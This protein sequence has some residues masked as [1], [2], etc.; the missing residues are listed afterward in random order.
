MVVP[1]WLM[2]FKA[3]CGK[4]DVFHIYTYSTCDPFTLQSKR[5]QRQKELPK[6][7][8]LEKN[9]FWHQN[10]FSPFFVLEICSKVMFFVFLITNKYLTTAQVVHSAMIRTCI[11][12]FLFWVHL[13]TDL[14]HHVVL[15]LRWAGGLDC[16]KLKS[17]LLLKNISRILQMMINRCPSP[18]SLLSEGSRSL[19]ESTTMTKY[20]G[21]NSRSRDAKSL[22]K[23]KRT[24]T[25]SPGLD[26]RLR[27]VMDLS[28]EQLWPNCLWI[29]YQ[30]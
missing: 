17:P 23:A 16:V 3:L 14:K 25:P 7:Q 10:F 27:P 28:L 5:E 12:A 11:S 21:G 18:F 20:E 26:S 15:T 9:K 13:R 8:K 2:K 4:L 1:S 22:L 19:S 29:Q 30:L 6:S 24:W